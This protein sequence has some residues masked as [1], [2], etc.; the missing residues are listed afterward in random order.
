VKVAVV[1]AAG[2]MGTEVCRAVSAAPD[3]ELA[4]ALD[5][6]DDRAAILAAG[7]QVAV[8]FTTPDAVMDN[9]RWCIEH[10][11]GA[12]VGTTGFDADRLD[13]VRSWLA[14]A[15]DVGVVVAPNFGIGAVLMMRFA[16]QAAPYFDSVEIVELHHAG[17]VDAP[18]GTARRTAELVAAARRD[19]GRGRRRTP[20]RRRCPAPAARRWTGCQCT[21]SASPASLRTR[22]CCSA[23]PGRR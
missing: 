17:K 10:G 20:P 5:V 4:G 13:A 3:L 22:R 12:V 7:A 16:A 11:V 23:R 9:L 6:G 1:G 21:R 8:D 18:S 19:A 2:R 15:P 14:A